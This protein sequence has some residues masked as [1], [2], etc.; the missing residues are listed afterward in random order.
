[1]EDKKDIL[2]S[3]NELKAQRTGLVDRLTVVVDEL[4]S[5]LGKSSDG[6]ENELVIS[7]RLYAEAV[8][9]VEVDV[10][11]TQALW[12]NLVGWMG[13]E[14]GGLRLARNLAK[15]L[16]TLFGFWIVGLVLGKLVDKALA[17]TRITVELMRSVIVRTVRRATYMVGIIVG[18]SAMEINVG[19][20]LAVVGAAGFV[21][22]FALQNTLSNF[23]SGIMIMIYRPYD[24]GDVINVSGITGV[25]RSMNLVS[26]TVATLDNQLL[27]VPNNSIWGNVITN[28]T[29]SE[30]RRVDLLFG[31]CY[32]DDIDVALRVLHQIVEQHPLVLDEPKPQI[33]VNALS[34]YKVEIICWP[35]ATTQDY[36]QVYRE[37]TRSVKEQ[38]EQAGFVTPYPRQNIRIAETPGANPG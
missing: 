4:S 23:A 22:A 3:V 26:T 25:A 31:I 35:W 9:Y 32:D 13:S 5:K 28:I 33:A 38:F 20:I 36:W 34:E 18:L 1:M 27:V 37:L 12:S 2:L 16:V 14:V 7:Y 10:S 19:P 24:V 11:D 8:S 17:M 15:F 21:V 6:V 29:G 30:T